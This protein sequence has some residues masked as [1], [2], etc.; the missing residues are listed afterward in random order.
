MLELLQ[1]DEVCI[2]LNV[3]C[4]K[5]AGRREFFG[6]LAKLIEIDHRVGIFILIISIEPDKRHGNIVLRHFEPIAA[7]DLSKVKL[8]GRGSASHQ[9]SH[10]E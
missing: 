5:R 7:F 2:R 8:F 6:I 10:R 9:K 1:S 4:S 3:R